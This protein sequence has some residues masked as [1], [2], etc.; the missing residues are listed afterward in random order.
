MKKLQ[1]AVVDP[2]SGFTMTE[3]LITI[4]IIAILAAAVFPIVSTFRTRGMQSSRE[5][6]ARTIYLSVQSELTKLHMEGTL[7]DEL[8]GHH[9]VWDAARGRWQ[10]DNTGEAYQLN[11]G[12]MNAFNADGF[13]GVTALALETQGI[14]FAANT[15]LAVGS[16]N[17]DNIR[18]ISKPAGYTLGGCGNAGC[19]AN[20]AT[21]TPTPTRC[22]LCCFF[23]ILQRSIT[24]PIILD[25][26]ILMEYN[27]LNGVIFSIFFGD[28][29][30]TLFIY[31]DPANCT[32]SAPGCVPGVRGNCDPCLNNVT[33]PRGAL[34]ASMDQAAVGNQ[35]FYGSDT[36]GAP[37]D[38]SELTEDMASIFDGTLCPAVTDGS[39]T[40]RAC[41]HT[42]DPARAFDNT[43]GGFEGTCRRLEGDR[44]VL[45]AEFFVRINDPANPFNY[46]SD[47][48]FSIVTADSTRS[49]PNVLFSMTQT[50]GQ[51]AALD[52]T[53]PFLSLAAAVGPGGT[54]FYRVP[55]DVSGTDVPYMING[56]QF[57]RYIWVIDHIGSDTFSSLGSFSTTNA[58]NIRAYVKGTGSPNGV[59]STSTANTHY[60]TEIGSGNNRYEI[61]SARHL[62]NVR[63]NDDADF[64]QTTNLDLTGVTAFTPIPSFSGSYFAKDFEAQ[65]LNITNAVTEIFDTIES[66]G[67]VR[68]LTLE[69]A[70]ITGAGALAATNNGTVSRVLVRDYI[71]NGIVANVGGIVGSNNGTV[72][73]CLVL[74]SEIRGNAA[75]AGGVVGANN[76]AI[77]R[78][79]VERTDI[80]TFL[81][82]S[83]VNAGGIVGTNSG[84]VI[85][86][87]FISTNFKEDVPMNGSSVAG[88]ITGM[89]SGSVTRAFYYGPAPVDASDQYFPI[90]GAGT[91]PVDSFYLA[92]VTYKRTATGT[93]GTLYNMPVN[94]PNGGIPMPSSAITKENLRSLYSFSADDLINWTQTALHPYPVLQFY[95][96][97]TG[98]RFP[99]SPHWPVASSELGIHQRE[100]SDHCNTGLSPCF[101]LCCNFVGAHDPNDRIGNPVDFINGDFNLPIRYPTLVP[102]PSGF[103]P[104]AGTARDFQLFGHAGV[105]NPSSA[106]N[107]FRWFIPS[108][109]TDATRTNPNFPFTQNHYTGSAFHHGG[110]YAYFKDTFVQGWNTRPTVAADFS[111]AYWNAIEFQ[112]YDPASAGSGRARANYAGTGVNNAYAELNAEIPGTLY[113]IAPTYTDGQELYYSYYHQSRT[114]GP[115]GSSLASP[116]DRMSFY[117]SELVAGDPPIIENASQLPARNQKLTLIRP[118]WSPRVTSG[119]SATNPNPAAWNN[120][121]YGYRYERV[122]GGGGAGNQTFS[123]SI[124]NPR[125]ATVTQIGTDSHLLRLEIDFDALGFTP[126]TGNATFNVSYLTNAGSARRFVVWTDLSGTAAMV[127][128]ISFATATRI[129]TAAASRVIERSG[130][131]TAASTS[132]GNITLP[133]RLIRNGTTYATVIYIL[134]TE[135]NDNANEAARNRGGG[136]QNEFSRLNNATL[137]MS[138]TMASDWIDFNNGVTGLRRYW[139]QH[140]PTGVNWNSP[141][142]VYVYDVWIGSR[143]NGYGVTFI[144]NNDHSGIG[145]TT[146]YGDINA[147]AGAVG[148]S[149]DTLERNIIGYWGVENGWKHYYGIYTVPN[150]QRQTEFAFQSNRADADTGNYLAGI[151]FK[152]PSFLTATTNIVYKGGFRDGERATSVLPETDLRVEMYIANHGEIPAD[153]IIVTNQLNPFTEFITYE[154]NITVTK[155]Y[156]DGTPDEI[157]TG[158]T[159]APNPAD[160]LS[161]AWT[162]GVDQTLTITLPP[163]TFL[164]RNE[165]LVVTFDI[166]VRE[167]CANAPGETTFFHWFENRATVYWREDLTLN[168]TK[169]N[170]LRGPAVTANCGSG[171]THAARIPTGSNSTANILSNCHKAMLQ[172]NGSNVEKVHIN[173]VDL[174]TDVRTRGNSVWSAETD[175][176]VFD[177]DEVFEVRLTATNMLDA[178]SLPDGFTDGTINGG[179]ITL[180]SELDYRISNIR[181]DDPG[182][183]IT[184]TP[185]RYSDSGAQRLVISI[186]D[187]A[188]GA[189][190]TITYDVRY[191]GNSYGASYVTPITMPN[192]TAVG[193]ALFAYRYNPEPDGLD[194]FISMIYPATVVGIRPELH[195]YTDTVLSSEMTIMDVLAYV[196]P[197]IRNGNGLI[198]DGYT[199]TPAMVDGSE[200]TFVFVDSAGDLIL[201]INS[202]GNFEVNIPGSYRAEFWK[203]INEVHFTPLGGANTYT[204]LYQM[205]ITANKPG[206]RSFVL[207]SL[208]APITVEVIDNGNLVYFEKY[209]DGTYGFTSPS[210]LPA[211]GAL[212]DDKTVSD[213]GYGVLHP[214]ASGIAISPSPVSTDSVGSTGLTLHVLS[215]STDTPSTNFALTTVQVNGTPMGSFHPNYAK[216]VY[217]T[218]VSDAGTTFAI[219]TGQ[220]M[221][222]ISST[223]GTAG[224]TY[225]LERDIEIGTIA[226]GGAA[227]TGIFNG[228]FNNLG[229]FTITDLYINMPSAT[230]VGL[231]STIGA[232]GTVTGVRLVSTDTKAVYIRGDEFVGA[233]AGNNLGT[234]TNCHVIGAAGNAI[235]II[236]NDNVG[237]FAGSG[238]LGADNDSANVSVE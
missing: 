190:R 19:A 183:T 32:G 110:Q 105:W 215:N 109:P 33:G 212:S 129:N 95:N 96:D 104:I 71:I 198:D 49:S 231:F 68:Q 179:I 209:S 30:Q 171:C 43:T 140:N 234:I 132:S 144:S 3:V 161:N 114:Q 27:I 228:T 22:E 147:L 123:W 177:K 17:R 8:T 143:P 162:N 94:S 208:P 125:D 166:K 31:D 76:G 1:R 232:S 45:Y 106:L 127:N 56:L 40:V 9:F 146:T 11:G 2:R 216:A 141:A 38:L 93:G 233:I 78:V 230:N 53:S 85:D 220:Q 23:V 149:R 204:F 75:S 223:A 135:N 81:S 124:N 172:H 188:P 133:N 207:D 182:V 58:T 72:E 187:L 174:Q 157:I 28:L 128:D 169:M 206:H 142:R 180:A 131:L 175:P 12:T 74:T 51:L 99:Q 236:G 82:S 92:G 20:P 18:Y 52:T 229:T 115:G 119:A 26:A 139:E 195:G 178:G 185:D 163:G 167:D 173:I 181:S 101:D 21:M 14:T 70:E 112:N 153:N 91:A 199:I 62:N 88:G 165:N 201:P 83:A 10:R 5:T 211:V 118:S 186:G 59:L 107:P 15:E 191:V 159:F 47:Y 48:E 113:Q 90:V 197:A 130:A 168:D 16:P 63:A 152:T 77:D 87:S 4:A 151:S 108:E 203:S 73:E 57:N 170:M 116:T 217:A 160:T 84:I 196:S 224:I 102:L 189:S 164:K 137:T 225:R 235:R 221:K 126:G 238:A 148:M 64:M 193:T 192:S 120:V 100:W 145:T 69:T 60:A 98:R 24:D 67:A 219:R 222:N 134:I 155:T 89:N 6:T 103:T 117:L 44:N 13:T 227:V 54:G 205:R 97:L 226:T 61:R 80:M 218:G 237:I 156:S 36:T 66:T 65:N 42:S 154:G 184:A 29:G 37:L 210:A 138:G 150:G 46:N 213:W 34:A 121:H 111:N 55:N 50:P 194:L 214:H 79:S 158:A 202:N 39:G 7:K 86:V 41:D 122:D 176:L 136:S 35:G 25:S 200:H